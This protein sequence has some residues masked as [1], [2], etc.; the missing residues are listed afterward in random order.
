MQ[1]LHRLDEVIPRVVVGWVGAQRLLV[2]G[3]GLVVLLL[4]KMT[5]TDVMHRLGVTGL[6][7][8]FIQHFRSG[9]ELSLRVRVLILFEERVTE[10]VMCLVAVL[11]LL[12]TTAVVHF[13]FGVVL[14]VV[15]AVAAAH[16]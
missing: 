2:R 13:R 1:H 7:G 6:V 10:V 8:L 15:L 5:V 12:Q 14:F 4:R 11:V 9:L 16:V 3:Y